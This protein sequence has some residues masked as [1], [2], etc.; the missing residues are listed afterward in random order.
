VPFAL[1]L[2]V[3]WPAI[4]IEYDTLK[5][6]GEAGS[7]LT[8]VQRTI[9]AANAKIIAPITPSFTGK[10]VRIG[11]LHRE[12]KSAPGQRSRLVITLIIMGNMSIKSIRSRTG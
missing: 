3:S 6:A 8:E 7:A 2:G 10:S 5:F 12:F 9:A 4:K 1:K 11:R